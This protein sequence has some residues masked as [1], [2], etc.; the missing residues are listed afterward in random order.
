MNEASLINSM[1]K[2]KIILKE[3]GIFKQE[4]L[5][6]HITLNINKFSVDF[7][8]KCQDSEYELIYKT[9][10][11]NT[12][13]DYLLKDDSIFQFSCSLRNGKINEGSIRY[14]YFQNPREYLTY[15]EFLKEIGFTYEECGD[16]LL[17]EYEQ[18]VAEAKLNNGVIPIRYDYNFS[19]YQ[20][21]HHPISHLHIGH[22]NQIRVALN[23][24]LTPQK[25]VIF[26]LR[27]VYPNIWKEVY[28]SNE[29]IMTICMES[30][31]CCPSLDKSIFSEEEEHLLFIV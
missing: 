23:K 27:N 14:A 24:I 5:T 17:L 19:M 7:F 22:N 29:K 26:V 30:K 16:E 18:D 8:Q 9:A 13:F 31:K 21:V 25:F 11:K 4:N 15:E 10:L 28:P 12:D 1:K 2:T 6:R 3:C 20:P